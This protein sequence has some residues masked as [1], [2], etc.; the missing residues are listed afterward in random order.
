V[1]SLNDFGGDV[2]VEVLKLPA[3]VTS[4]TATKLT[5]PRRGVVSTSFKLQASGDAALGDERFDRAHLG[6]ADLGSGPAAG[7]LIVKERR[8]R[9]GRHSCKVS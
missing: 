3:G 7:V 4:Q 6:S 1:L 9:R 8:A 5:V 2:K